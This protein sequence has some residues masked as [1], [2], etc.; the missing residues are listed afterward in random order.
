VLSL[1][2]NRGIKLIFKGS[3]GANISFPVSLGIPDD[4]VNCIAADGCDADRNSWLIGVVN[5][6]PYLAIMAL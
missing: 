6:T 1:P 4:P 3:N 5:A 2:P